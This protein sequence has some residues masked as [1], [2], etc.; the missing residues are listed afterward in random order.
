VLV[1]LGVLAA[2]ARAPEVSPW[3]RLAD[4]TTPPEQ[5]WTYRPEEG[6]LRSALLAGGRLV[7]STTH[8]LVGLDPASGA[9]RWSHA[10]AWPRCTS[11]GE[12]L[13]CVPRG[14]TVLDLDPATGA[15]V[16]EQT[17][18]DAQLATRQGEDLYVITDDG[19]LELHRLTAGEQV[20]ST[21]LAEPSLSITHGDQLAVIAGTVLTDWSSVADQPTYAAAAALDAQTGTSVGSAD[22]PLLVHQVAPGAWTATT[23]ATGSRYLREEERPAPIDPAARSVGYDEDWQGTDD[24]RTGPDGNVAVFDT[25]SDSWRWQTDGPGV[26]LARLDG[27]LV[28]LGFEPAPHLRAQDA[29]TGELLWQHEHTTGECPCLADEHT[30]VLVTSSVTAGEQGF[31]VDRPRL[32]ALDARTGAVH[33]QLDELT[34][35]PQVLTDGEHLIVVTPQAITGFRLG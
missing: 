23:T 31:A 15:T 33:W 25:T 17:V 18:A 20:W 14:S 28:G 32:T 1:L 4:V 7:V 11:D 24:L 35:I 6:G 27:V 26:A 19:S 3:Q 30:L 5:V 2:P 21:R 13:V 8:G 10:L 34:R 9:Q 29:A 16:A 12:D 22:D